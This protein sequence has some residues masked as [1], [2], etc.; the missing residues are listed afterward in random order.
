[1]LKI[2]RI[3]ICFALYFIMTG[4]SVN[5][6][7]L[8]FAPDATIIEKAIALQMDKQYGVLSTHLGTQKPT[9]KIEKINI[10]KIEPSNKFN[11]PTYHLTGDYLVIT[12]NNKNKG[13]KIKNSF[14]LNLQRQNAGKT[15]RLLLPDTNPSSDKYFSYQIP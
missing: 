3:L 4:C 6:P 9:I 10:R 11:L 15:W 2:A 14:T 12:K 13:K 7:P 1:M 8:E 5:P